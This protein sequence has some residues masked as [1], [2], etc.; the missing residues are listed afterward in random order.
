L[1][2]VKLEKKVQDKKT[3]EIVSWLRDNDDKLRTS[4]VDLGR[5][6]KSSRVVHEGSG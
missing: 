4:S 3:D 2:S 5:E 1:E 6:R